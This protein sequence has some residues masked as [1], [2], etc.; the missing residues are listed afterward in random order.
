VAISYDSV[1]ILQ[2]FSERQGG[3]RYTML[4]DSESQII[5]DFGLINPDAEPGS[6]HYGMAY[7]GSYIV[8]ADGIV[9]HKFFDESYRQRVTAK[10]LLMTTYAA[11]EGH[12][13]RIETDVEP[14]FKLTVS[15]TQ[16]SVSGGQ[17]ISLVADIELYDKVHLYAPGSSYRAIDIKITDNP[18]LQQGELSLPEPEM[19]YL[20]AIDETVPVYH[21]KVRIS[22]E[23][24]V[25]PLYRG[26]TV[27][28]SATLSYQTCDD[29]LCYLPNEMPLEFELK[30]VPHDR[31]RSSEDL[32]HQDSPEL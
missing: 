21:G 14:Q 11:G 15:P 3:I 28:I 2:S 22:R 32:R 26:D 23:V 16:D 6:M 5:K 1:E 27:T 9:Q 24:A 30:M 13:P 25:S 8:D 20:E 18:V 31:T 7:P 4:A 10:T 19:I 17:T 29:E 12:G